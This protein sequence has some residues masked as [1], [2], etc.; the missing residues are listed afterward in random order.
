MIGIAMIA[1]TL[2]LAQYGSGSQQSSTYE[3][4]SKAGIDTTP[5]VQLHRDCFDKA[6]GETQGAAQDLRQQRF[7]TCFALHD[8]MVKHATAKLSEKEAIGVKRD[9]DRALQR[10]E[11]NYAKKLGVAMPPEAK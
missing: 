3:S 5:F 10:V 6:V 7:D 8:A 11:K 9:L 1:G 2:V 4:N